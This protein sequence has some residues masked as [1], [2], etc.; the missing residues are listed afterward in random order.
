MRHAAIVLAAT[1]LAL[2]LLPGCGDA[3]GNAPGDVTR[4]PVRVTV[5]MVEERTDPVEVRRSATLLSRVD[6][7]LATESAGLVVSR[8][9]PAGTRVAKDTVVLRLSDTAER[10]ALTAAR[11]RLA[12]LAREGVSLAERQTASAAVRQAEKLLRMRTVVAHAD[13]TLDRYDI[14]EGDYAVPGAR[15]GRLVDPSRL[16]L[17]ATVLENEILEVKP[18]TAVWIE[19]P[20]WPDARFA[21]KVVRRGSAALPGTG[22]FEVEVD[23]DTDAR[24]LPGF[25]ATVGIPLDG[26][27][28][29]RLVPRDAVFQRHGTWR[30]F[31]VAEDDGTQRAKEHAVHVRTVPGHPELVDITDGVDSGTRIV[32]RGRIGLVDGDPLR[33]EDR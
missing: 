26:S 17:I 28:A 18:G 4:S 1:A 30:L 21:G 5:V 9:I 23:V 12:G 15:V 29:R 31:A 16:W 25:V 19:V 7:H 24:L 20:A 33:I 14:E 8:P 27:R 10:A 6:V 32:V 11:A 13:G 22:Q 2:V 3:A